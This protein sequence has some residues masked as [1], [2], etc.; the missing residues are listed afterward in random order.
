M[1]NMRLNDLNVNKFFNKNKSPLPEKQVFSDEELSY[2]FSMMVLGLHH[3][4][5]E[6]PPIKHRDIKP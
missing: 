6:D 5:R 4:H 2:M 3:M 1:A